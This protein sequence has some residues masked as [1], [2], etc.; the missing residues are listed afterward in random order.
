VSARRFREL[1][2]ASSS[3]EIDVAEP[4]EKTV[5]PLKVLDIGTASKE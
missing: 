2:A 3:M 1:G 5:R 4:V